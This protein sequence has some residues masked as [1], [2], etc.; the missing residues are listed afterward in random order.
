[1]STCSDKRMDRQRLTR[2]LRVAISAGCLVMFVG[3]IG[4]WVRSYQA[5][6]RTSGRIAGRTPAIFVSY[7]GHL[8][9]VLTDVRFL[10]WNWPQWDSGP[11]LPN[12][13]TDADLSVHH[14]NWSDTDVVW[15][16]PGIMGFGWIYRSMYLNIPNPENGW[17]PRGLSGRSWG[18]PCTGFMVPHWFGLLIFGSLAGLPWIRCQFRYSLRTLLIVTTLVAVVLGCVVWLVRA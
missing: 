18:A 8:T 6:D 14:V 9:A 17:S 11:I 5:F 4:L 3:L 13:W 15:P 16:F 1:M 12:N 10:N 2:W 7:A